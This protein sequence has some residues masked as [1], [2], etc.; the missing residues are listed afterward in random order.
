LKKKEISKISARDKR[1]KNSYRTI[2]IGIL[3]SVPR[4]E[5]TRSSRNIEKHF[6]L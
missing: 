1:Y 3:K 4:L 2:L 5:K 6:Q